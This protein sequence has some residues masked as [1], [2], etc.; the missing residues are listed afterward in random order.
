MGQATD[1]WRE[2]M[3]PRARERGRWKG[4]ERERGTMSKEKKAYIERERWQALK[5]ETEP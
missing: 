4:R 5:S 1:G 2:T 3:R